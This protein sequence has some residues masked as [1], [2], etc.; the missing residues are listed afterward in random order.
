LVEIGQ[1]IGNFARRTKYILLLPAT[2]NRHDSAL[3][4]WNGIRLSRQPKRYKY[5]VN[6]PQCYFI[7]T[8]T[9]WPWSW[10]ITV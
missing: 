7:R 3:F 6:A 1:N 10:T 9:L 4:E 5:Y 8:L 2:L